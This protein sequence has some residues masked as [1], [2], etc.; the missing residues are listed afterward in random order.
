MIF[1]HILTG[2]KGTL[3][4]KYYVPVYGYMIQIKLVDGRVYYAPASEF[5]E[6]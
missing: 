4:K 5:I 6:I 1:R 2:N 3:I